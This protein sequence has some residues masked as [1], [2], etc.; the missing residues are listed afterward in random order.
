MGWIAASIVFVF[1]LWRFPRY[2]IIGAACLLLIAGVGFGLSILNDNQNAARRRDENSKV[3]LIVSATDVHCTDPQY[4]IWIATVNRNPFTI[5]SIT[6]HVSANKPDH[7]SF[8]Y[9][10]YVTSDRILKPQDGYAAC[11]RLEDYKLVNG[12]IGGHSPRDLSWKGAISSI[13]KSD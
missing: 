3:E 10:A 5:A 2:T 7:S 11:W 9:D 13:E 12:T 6:V 8:L 4:P 1:L